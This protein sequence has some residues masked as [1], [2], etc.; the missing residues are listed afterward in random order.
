MNAR[1]WLE[2]A[3]KGMPEVVWDRVQA[4]TLAH[5]ED[6]GVGE[7]ADVR[8][9]L[10]SPKAMRRELGRLYVL[11]HRLQDLIDPRERLSDI[12]CVVVPMVFL[13]SD[14]MMRAMFLRSAWRP[15]GEIIGYWR[16]FTPEA[17]WVLLGLVTLIGTRRLVL[18]RRRL[19]RERV[20]NLG[21]LAWVSVSTLRDTS[22]SSVFDLFFISGPP[23][24]LVFL[25]IVTWHEDRRL[26]RT[27][28][29]TG[30]AQA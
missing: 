20:T 26:R 6:A 7:G 2:Q 8:A 15:P 18:A 23:L 25:P 30:E 11:K 1:E 5:L 24:L 3:T 9:V 17:L 19:W 21:M 22:F 12:F 27:L 14:V 4:E 29:L 28:S 13:V 16:E 10:G